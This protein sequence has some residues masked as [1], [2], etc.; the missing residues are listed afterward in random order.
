MIIWEENHPHLVKNKFLL[1]KIKERVLLQF[2]YML[3]DSYPNDSK[4]KFDELGSNNVLKN[5]SDQI[6]RLNH[7]VE[8]LTNELNSRPTKA[9]VNMLLKNMNEITQEN[10][11]LNAKLDSI[12]NDL[13]QRMNN[14]FDQNE[15]SMQ[16]QIQET[17]FSVNSVVRAQNALIEKKV[18]EMTK[19][20]FEF[21]EMKNN[22]AE[23]KNENV[24]I[25][26]QIQSLLAFVSSYSCEPIPSIGNPK[27]TVFTQIEKVVMKERERISSIEREILN[28]IQRFEKIEGHLRY[29]IDLN[30][31]T[32]PSYTPVEKRSSSEKPK[33]P[34]LKNPQTYTDYFV[35]LMELVPVLQR[36][37]T[38]HYEKLNSIQGG[39]ITSSSEGF[40]LNLKED[41]MADFVQKSEL[42]KIEESINSLKQSILAKEEMGHIEQTLNTIQ[43]S[44]IDKQ[45]FDGRIGKL[46]QSIERISTTSS[47]E[48]KRLENQIIETRNHIP[49]APVFT[50][51]MPSGS[52]S[53][54]LIYDERSSTPAIA[55]TTR[56]YPKP[57]TQAKIHSRLSGYKNTPN[58]RIQMK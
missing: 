44:Y 32:L 48:L 28:F 34:K 50:D 23:I 43:E 4:D 2:K 37:L 11:K 38:S 39:G 12:N 25:V 7:Q 8:F 51:V 5:L 58:L 9:E 35:Y 24:S 10:F 16:N 36:I 15:K 33:L 19:P 14:L 20:T 18:H 41:H 6:K 57:D 47:K 42:T 49:K 1:I 3:K 29:V 40:L 45:E 52:T 22:L 55:N 13:L 27:N 31:G 54:K 26:K 21:T 53:F 56:S 17:V 30:K 46:A